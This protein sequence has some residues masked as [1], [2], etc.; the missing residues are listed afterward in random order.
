MS[1]EEKL[2]WYAALDDV[3]PPR[4]LAEDVLV[5]ARR[6]VRNRRIRLAATAGLATALV[7]IGVAVAVPRLD[8]SPVPT[9]PSPSVVPSTPSPTAP[10]LHCRAEALPEPGGLTPAQ[11]MA[12]AIDPSGR[13]IVGTYASGPDTV[14]LLMW[15]DGDLRQPAAAKVFAATA[16][17]SRG[18][19]IGKAPD[20]DGYKHAA[21]F[22][23]GKVSL[24][25]RPAGTM[26]SSALAI[27]THGDIVGTVSGNDLPKYGGSTEDLPIL[28]PAT[29]G[30]VLLQTGQDDLWPHTA[31]AIGDDGVILG[32]VLRSGGGFTISLPYRWNADRTG[33]LLPLPRPLT[34]K[35]AGV[36][37][38]AG[39][40]AAGSAG[41]LP[42]AQAPSPA[43]SL[44][45]HFGTPQAHVRWNLATG[46]FEELG[47]FSPYGVSATGAMI[48][49]DDPYARTPAVWR[50]GT[51]TPLPLLDPGRS[52]MVYGGVSADGTT[53]F[54]TMM[55]PVSTT[56]GDPKGPYDMVRWRC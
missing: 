38:M 31:A 29:G 4:M 13:Y 46:A 30:Y 20:R 37:A 1:A 9:H 47:I 18:V 12:R 26:Y 8:A 54:G 5:T 24:L 51:V 32:T 23:D 49:A 40:W 53:A 21:V 17:N 6:K 27:N 2:R 45:V 44:D 15:T 41:D 34:T 11:R 35:S 7:L 22:R 42:R 25:P 55:P 14:G 48:G 19:V 33:A 56:S 16:V 10:P 28:W 50:G 3:P 52:F 36:A 39:Q 43:P